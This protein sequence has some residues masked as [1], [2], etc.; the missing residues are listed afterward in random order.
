MSRLSNRREWRMMLW[1]LIVFWCAVGLYDVSLRS[2]F[3]DNTATRLLA[4]LAIS[5]ILPAA[6]ITML[7]A[8][9]VLMLDRNFQRPLILVACSTSL[10]L[11]CVGATFGHIADLP[12]ERTGSQVTYGAI[13]AFYSTKV[14]GAPQLVAIR[15][16]LLGPQTLAALLPLLALYRRIVLPPVMPSQH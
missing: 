6:C 14:L 3:I 11:L 15:V 2:S 5:V 9:T 7:T 1:G 10:V 16:S 4:S 12:L 8:A 13:K